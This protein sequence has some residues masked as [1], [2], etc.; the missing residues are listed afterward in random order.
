MIIIIFETSN[1]FIFFIHSEIYDI[2]REVLFIFEWFFKIFLL[3]SFCSTN[4]YPRTLLAQYIEILPSTGIERIFYYLLLSLSIGCWL[5]TFN[6]V[7]PFL[8]LIRSSLSLNYILCSYA[9]FTK[10]ACMNSEAEIFG[11]GLQLCYSLFYCLIEILNLLTSDI[12]SL[13]QQ[14]VL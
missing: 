9:L 2:Q 8:N 14:F 4:Q 1:L 3:F 7:V 13:K 6:W 5:N 12:F 11:I 10:L